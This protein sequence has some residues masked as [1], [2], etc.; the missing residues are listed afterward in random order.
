MKNI[1]YTKTGDKGTTSLIG[2]KRVPKYDDRVEAYGTV[3]ELSAYIGV[4]NDLEGVSE[5]IRAVL[6]VIQQKLFTLESHFALDKSSEVSKM[7]PLLEDTD[8]AFLEGHIDEMNAVLQS[9]EL[10]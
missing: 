10:L 4:L 9:C 6:G 5:E 1:T 8:V 7:I 2:G 3:D